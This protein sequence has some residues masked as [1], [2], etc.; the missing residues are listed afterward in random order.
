MVM[1][2]KVVRTFYFSG[3]LVFFINNVMMKPMIV[4]LVALTKP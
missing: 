3:S 4:R 1:E 2:L